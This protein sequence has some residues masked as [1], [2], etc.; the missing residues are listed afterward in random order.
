MLYSLLPL[1]ICLLQ[2]GFVRRETVGEGGKGLGCAWCPLFSSMCS[3]A[4]SSLAEW[5]NLW[6]LAPTAWNGIIPYELGVLRHIAY[7][8]C[9]SVFF[10]CKRGVIRAPNSNHIVVK[11]KG[12]YSVWHTVRAQYALILIIIIIIITTRF[13]HSVDNTK[14]PTFFTKH[15]WDS[16]KNAFFQ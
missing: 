3:S 16:P 7:P 10:F 12:M 5:S 11:C 1:N 2:Q 4:R 6:A 9:I 14:L 8:P 13:L 15:F